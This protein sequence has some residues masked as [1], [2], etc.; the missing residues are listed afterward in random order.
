[1]NAWLANGLLRLKL[2]MTR[3]M[4]GRRIAATLHDP[5]RVQ[6]ALLADIIARNKD[7]SFGRRYGFADISD[8]RSF[9]RAVPVGDF[10]S[11]RPYVEAEIERGEAALTA[12]A[13]IA[14]VRTSGTTGK[15]KDVP[16]TSAHLARLRRIHETAVSFQHAICPEA[17]D[18]SILA[19]VSP[20]KEG[21]LAN[22]K[23]FG[24]ASGIVSRDTPRLV[25]SKFIVPPVVLA[26]EDSHLKYLVITR[27]ALARKDLTYVGVANATTLLTLGRLF[28]EHRDDLIEDLRNGTFFLDDKLTPDVRAAIRSVL[29]PT[30][31]RAQEVQALTGQGGESEIA[32]LWPNLRMIVCW[33]CASA[34]VAVDS[35]R[36]E[37]L[38]ST[39]ICE[40]GYISSEFRGTVT[41]GRRAGSG[42]PTLDSH[43]FEFVERE[44]WDAGEPEFLTLDRLRKGG[45]YYVIVTTPSGLYRY[46]INDLVRVEGK[47][48]GTPLLRFL[49][50]GKGVTNITGEKLYEAQVLTAVRAAVED[51]GRVPYFVMMLA[52]DVDRVYRLYVETDPGERPAA[53][54][55]A[56]MVDAKLG[57]LNLEYQAKRE[58]GRLAPLEAHWL[59]PN[60]AET[61]KQHCVRQGQ[62][63]GQFKTIALT[64]RKDC[65]FDFEHHIDRT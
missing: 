20:A 35:L 32:R 45:V 19:I 23:S 48:H 33:T 26:I 62:R 30:P 9:G 18:G 63:E 42:L 2:R 49:Q 34:G 29:K 65:P 27:L 6:H 40:L 28:L 12:D 22:G 59:E 44:R 58:S 31:E 56:A 55:L 53:T 4:Q 57:A 13:P 36:R 52:D 51:L 11:F 1:L 50:K 25:S 15:P 38:P 41:I 60:V 14:Y 64:Y 37:V 16:L 46:F 8:Y 61:Y 54:V 21:V 5:M 3:A 47:L 17:F 39:R 10:E 24:S 43:F 7:T